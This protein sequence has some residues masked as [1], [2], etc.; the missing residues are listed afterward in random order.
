MEGPTQFK[1]PCIPRIRVEDGF[2]RRATIINHR[3]SREAGFRHR[4]RSWECRTRANRARTIR[5]GDMQR[6]M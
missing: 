1:I 5:D 6:N 3:Y 4:F 2:S